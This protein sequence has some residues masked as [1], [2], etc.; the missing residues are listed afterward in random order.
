MKRGYLKA[1]SCVMG[2]ALVLSG[3]GSSG[4]SS[5]AATENYEAAAEE[6]YATDDVYY[7]EEAA[8][9]KTSGESTNL[10]NA[11]RKLIKTVT[12]NVETEE[13][14]VLLSHVNSRILELGGY[15][16]N[17]DVGRN[18]Y[19]EESSRYANITARIPKEK[20][21]SFVD[22]VSEESNVIGKTENVE[23]VTL[24][25]VDIESH[26]K[27]LETEE[28]RL[29]E[30]M[31]Q[32]ENMADIIAIESR[33]SEI[34]Y[35]KESYTS[36]MRTFDNQVDY[37][38]IHLYINEVQ[39]LTPMEEPGAWERISTGFAANVYNVTKGIKNFAIELVIS[40]PYLIVFGVV[41]FLILL[42]VRLIGRASERKRKKFAA[43]RQAE[44]RTAT[45]KTEEQTPAIHKTTEEGNE[46]ES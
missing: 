15:V 14:D 38:T 1:I 28:K 24:Q 2:I 33:L 21:D 13:F 27:A 3:C 11:D 39:T 29:L 22:Q 37:T 23:D 41:V 43:M 31:E 35:Q 32:A 25:Y 18:G 10:V 4:K 7:E 17:S 40:I 5:M 36:Q 45:Q 16:E 6:N 26:K 19:G 42:I 30:L 44:N 20:S 9:G 46:P 34:R 8:A 12:M